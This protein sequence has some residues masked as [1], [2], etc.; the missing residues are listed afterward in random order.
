MP[1]RLRVNI[2]ILIPGLFFSL[3]KLKTLTTKYNWY[4]QG[5]IQKE[6]VEIDGE[7]G[8]QISIVAK[9]IVTQGWS[10]IVIMKYKQALLYICFFYFLVIFILCYWFDQ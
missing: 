3:W 5:L 8:A 2:H 10:E 9:E 1:K 6:K 7:K 4:P